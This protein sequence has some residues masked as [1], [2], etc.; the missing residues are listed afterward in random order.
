[1]RV[2]I[3]P[4]PLRKAPGDTSEAAARGKKKERKEDSGLLIYIK[5]GP[6]MLSEQL[7]RCSEGPEHCSSASAGVSG[8]SREVSE[9]LLG[10]PGAPSG[11][12]W[13]APGASRRPF[14]KHFGPPRKR[15]EQK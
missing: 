9:R 2:E 13:G 6:G 4:E 3:A 12:S 11:G 15:L 14:W 5:N 1:M 10:P 8:R 7:P